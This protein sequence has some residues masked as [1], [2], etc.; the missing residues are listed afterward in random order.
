MSSLVAPASLDLIQGDID[1]LLEFSIDFAEKFSDDAGLSLDDAGS[2]SSAG[3]ALVLPLTLASLYG[4]LSI[5]F[6]SLVNVAIV[7]FVNMA[8]DD[9]AKILFCFVS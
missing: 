9:L 5:F 4:F 7:D 6:V 8:M 2:A 3:F 1:T